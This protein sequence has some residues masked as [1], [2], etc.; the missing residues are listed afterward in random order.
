MTFSCPT[1]GPAEED[2]AGRLHEPVTVYDAFSVIRIDALPRIVLEDRGAGLLDLE[3]E[4]ISFRVRQQ[5]HPAG[6]A[7]APDA[8]DLVRGILDFVAIE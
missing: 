3:N 7:N 2:V 6:G 4:R 5:E 8:D 1:L